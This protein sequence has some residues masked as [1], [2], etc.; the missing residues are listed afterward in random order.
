[1]HIGIEEEIPALE[2]MLE[3]AGLHSSQQNQPIEEE[4]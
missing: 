3:I 1:M 2:G 4:S